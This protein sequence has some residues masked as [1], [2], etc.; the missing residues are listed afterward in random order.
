MIFLDLSELPYILLYNGTNM[1][2]KIL[3]KFY[4]VNKYSNF[5]NIIKRFSSL[6]IP[7]LIFKSIY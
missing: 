1:L 6:K 7:F 4:L 2:N 3:N 5:L